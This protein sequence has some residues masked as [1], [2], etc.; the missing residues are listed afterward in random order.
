MQYNIQSA[1]R[2]TYVMNDT[3]WWWAFLFHRLVHSHSL[4]STS[5]ILKFLGKIKILSCLI[6]GLYRTWA[7]D[8]LLETKGIGHPESECGW[9]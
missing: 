1:A 9:T 3:S 4:C 7:R 2:T 8:E 6:S 5:Y